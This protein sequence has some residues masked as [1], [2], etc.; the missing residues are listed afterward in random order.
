MNKR[1][2]LTV[3]PITTLHCPG[4]LDPQSQPKMNDYLLQFLSW[5]SPIAFLY[6][7]VRRPRDCWL[8]Y[9]CRV[10]AAT[11][12]QCLHLE[13]GSSCAAV[14]K[15]CSCGGFNLY[16]WIEMAV[17][18]LTDITAYFVDCRQLMDTHSN[19]CKIG[20]HQNESVVD[21]VLSL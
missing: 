3:C 8:A 1:G 15:H 4:P 17:W 7:S 6:L 19:R 2:L 20:E 14:V 16:V 18:T 5:D 21:S 12:H 11:R 10:V 13:S 9:M